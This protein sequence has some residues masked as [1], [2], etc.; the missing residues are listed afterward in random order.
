MDRKIEIKLPEGTFCSSRNC[1][2]CRYADWDRV[3][4]KGYVYC[5]GGYGGWNHPSNR[6]GCLHWKQG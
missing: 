6:E 2:N 4:S 3:D 1:R 5:T